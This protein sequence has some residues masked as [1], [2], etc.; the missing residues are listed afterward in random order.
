MR[1]RGAVTAALFSINRCSVLAYLLRRFVRAHTSCSLLCRAVSKR[2][3][4][5]APLGSVWFLD[6]AA[7]S[8]WVALHPLFED[9]STNWYSLAGRTPPRVATV[10]APLQTRPN[11]LCKPCPL[12]VAILM[13]VVSDQIRSP[14]LRHTLGSLSNALQVCP[15]QPL[16]P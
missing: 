15:R 13:L 16:A 7:H 12:F 6:S 2:R 4:S 9:F 1:R 11:M 14:Q 8:P 3:H 5:K 10:P